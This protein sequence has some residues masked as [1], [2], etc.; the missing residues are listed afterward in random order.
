MS[1]RMCRGSCGRS[2]SGAALMIALGVLAI[3][4]MLGGAF[5]MFMRVEQGRAEY[6][7]DSLRARYVARGGI[8]VARQRIRT[9]DAPEGELN[10]TLGEGTYTV[11]ISDAQ[12]AY[13]ARATGT[14]VRPTGAVI[15]AEI[16]ARMKAAEGNVHI[17]KWQ[18]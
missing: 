17:E 8:E 14:I 9:V 16:T 3:L 15:S 11:Q 4:A 13:E 2:D 1:R 7:L 18:E 6:E 10:G 12:G 5:V